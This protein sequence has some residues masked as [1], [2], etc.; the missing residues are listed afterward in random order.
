MFY[1]LYS[2]FHNVSELEISCNI[3]IFSKKNKQNDT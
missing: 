1:N 3:E 2:V